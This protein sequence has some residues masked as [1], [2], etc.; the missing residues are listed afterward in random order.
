M[1]VLIG[2]DVVCGL[3]EAELVPL[4]TVLELRGEG[5]HEALLRRDCEGGRLVV[6]LLRG[7]LDQDRVALTLADALGRPLAHLTAEVLHRFLE[8]QGAKRLA[9]ALL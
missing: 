8:R 2:I 5:V 3:L 4:F 1:Y 7:N 6:L 9:L